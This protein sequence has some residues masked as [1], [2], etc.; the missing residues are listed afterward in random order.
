MIKINTEPEIVNA[1]MD[2]DIE[3][4]LRQTDYYDKIICGEIRCASCDS[5]ISIERIGIIIPTVHSED[6][7]TLSFYCENLTCIEKYHNG[8]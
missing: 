8:K 1:V 7:F 2:S 3:K 4:L 6:N 5:P